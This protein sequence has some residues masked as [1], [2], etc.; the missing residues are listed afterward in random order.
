MATKRTKADKAQRQA[1]QLDKK[2]ERRP[3]EGTSKE[4]YA[5]ISAEPRKSDRESRP[6]NLGQESLT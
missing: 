4:K 1:D 2:S 5:R 6:R 3:E